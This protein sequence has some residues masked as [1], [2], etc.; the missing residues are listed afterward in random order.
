MR[1]RGG[2]WKR[3][4]AIGVGAAVLLLVGGPFVYIHFVEGRAPAP[5]ALASPSSD[6][7]SGDPSKTTGTD[8][9]WKVST[10]SLVGYRVKEV[11]FGQSNVAVG[12]TGKIAGSMTVS[13][14]SITAGSFTVDMA[15]VT[16]DQSRRDEQFNGRIMDTGAFP[17]ATF[18]LTKPIE[19]ASIPAEGTEKTV[20][21]TGELTLHGVTRTVAFDL[22][23]RL[24][25]SEVQVAGS[26]PVTFAD[27][28][29]P[30]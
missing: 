15:T 20:R 27:W 8:S 19:L 17:T 29:S 14:T 22:T 21:A 16:S 26:I 30:N 12:R 13:G 6:A 1:G 10:G 18:E 28:N 11:L 23:G 7:T 4:L 3:W 5:L 9:T 2:L 25:G 24:T